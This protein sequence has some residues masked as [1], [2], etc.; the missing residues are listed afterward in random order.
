MGWG[1]EK[2]FRCGI[3]GDLTTRSDILKA[4]PDSKLS[5]CYCEDCGIPFYEIPKR[6]YK[7]RI[8]EVI[9]K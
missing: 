7:A 2:Y 4:Q 5:I 8:K 9:K 6:E 1:R 3:C